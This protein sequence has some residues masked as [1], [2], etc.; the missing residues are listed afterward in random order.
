MCSL[1][2]KICYATVWLFANTIQELLM[3]AFATAFNARIYGFFFSEKRKKPPDSLVPKPDNDRLSAD[4]TVNA[5]SSAIN[6]TTFH[7]G[8]KRP[9]K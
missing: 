2:L 6:S 7:K 9:R 1:F 3:H 5:L 4:S 8:V